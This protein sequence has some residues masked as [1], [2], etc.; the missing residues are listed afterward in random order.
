MEPE[1]TSAVPSPASGGT[2]PP[3]AADQRVVVFRGGSAQACAEPSLVLSAVGV[4]SELLQVEHEVW[5]VV[6]A[7]HG[8]RARRELR[9]YVEENRAAARPAA[10]FVPVSTGV[11][12]AVAWVLGLLV[13]R[14]A[15]LQGLFGPRWLERAGADAARIVDGGELW[16]TV[17][18]LFLHTDALHLGSN[19]V[20]GALF[21]TFLAQSLGSGAAALMLVLSGGLG[22]LLNALALYPDHRS[23]GASTAVFGA[24]GAFVVDEALRRQ[25]TDREALRRWAPLLLGVLVLGWFGAGGER[26][27]V[28]AHLFGFLAGGVLSALLAWIGRRRHLRSARFQGLCAAGAVGLAALALAWAALAR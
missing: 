21:A 25:A 14:F 5:V 17:T 10:A 28:S 24:L 6:P 27:D 2:V 1:S 18:A 9:A 16:R 13:L 26:T 3:P 15:E 12:V 8:A 20:F 23:I 19:L 11:S 7:E 4:P 22:N